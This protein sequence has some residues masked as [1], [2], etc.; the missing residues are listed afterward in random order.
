MPVE[1]P[2]A[3]YLKT[4]LGRKQFSGLFSKTINSGKNA[5]VLVWTT[6]S[7]RKSASNPKA[8]QQTHQADLSCGDTHSPFAGGGGGGDDNGDGDEDDAINTDSGDG[9]SDVSD[10]DNDMMVTVMTKMIMIMKMLLRMLTVMI[11]E[12]MAKTIIVTIV[13]MVMM[14][15][16]KFFWGG[17]STICKELD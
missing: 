2:D 16:I 13:M 14:M 7:Q 8:I 1:N 11:V 10:D 15:T 9:D 6:T 12:M 4:I 3:G 5:R 17:A